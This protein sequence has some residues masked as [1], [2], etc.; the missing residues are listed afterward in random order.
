MSRILIIDDENVLRTNLRDVLTFEGFDVVEADNGNTGVELAFK[1][2]PD[3]VICD[4]A[5]PEMDGFAVL[6]RLREETSTESVPVIML[7]ARAE[8]VARQ[9]G[10]SLGA[11]AYI[12][13]PFT[14]DEILAVIR[15]HLE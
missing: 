3:L 12:T 2:Q 7:T 14:I 8:P 4:V 1:C 10:E 6:T 11:S 13:K 9:R 15:E 5:M